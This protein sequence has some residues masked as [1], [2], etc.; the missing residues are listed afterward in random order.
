VFLYGT[1]CIYEIDSSEQLRMFEAYTVGTAWE[2]L[3]L[4]L[5]IWIVFKHLREMR[6]QSTGRTAIS[7]CFTVL[8]KT[9]VFYFL[10]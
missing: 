7:D 5:A 1:Q 3:T 10:M 9:H 8:L 6:P 2:A 4:C